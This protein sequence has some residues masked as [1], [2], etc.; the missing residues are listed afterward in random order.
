M[1]FALAVLLSVASQQCEEYRTTGYIQGALDPFTADGTSTWT[2]ENIAAASYNVRMGSIVEVYFP[3]GVE[4]YRIA[5]RGGGL[6]NR[7]ID[8]QVK[9][10]TQAYQRTGYHPV[11]IRN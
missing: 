11:C 8:I 2:T 5:D 6:E 1:F 9:N 4:V 3:W 7:H 10:R